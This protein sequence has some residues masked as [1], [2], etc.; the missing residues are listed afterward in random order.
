VSGFHCYRT[1]SDGGGPPPRYR[2]RDSARGGGRRTG[3]TSRRRPGRAS[4]SRCAR[5]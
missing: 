3:R 2:P 4:R 5:T 1:L